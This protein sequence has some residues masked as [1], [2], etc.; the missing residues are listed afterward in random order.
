MNKDHPEPKDD[1]SATT[2]GGRGK[3]FTEDKA[4]RARERLRELLRHGPFVGDRAEVCTTPPWLESDKQVGSR[5]NP[6][7]RS[8]RP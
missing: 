4:A 3:I 6:I 5:D 8:R 2:R 7:M 1:D